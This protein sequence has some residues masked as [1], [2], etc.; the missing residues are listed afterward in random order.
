MASNPFFSGRIPQ[1]LLDQVEKHIQDTGESK[2]NILIQALAA[3]LNF[4]IQLSNSSNSTLEKRLNDLEQQ[5]EKL[6]S[7]NDDISEIKQ[8]ITDENKVDNFVIKNDNVKVPD[9]LPNSE[10]FD[11]KVINDDNTNKKWNLVGQMNITD[12]LKLPKLEIQDETK[13]RD[14]LKTL[15]N[16][17]KEKVTVVGFY[18]FKIIGKEP[19]ARGKIIYEVYE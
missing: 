17:K 13:F 14:K 10:A 16:S 5:V 19:G 1:E 8:I 7:L 9:R 2:T 4:P 15:N 6:L 3:Y 12:I 18:Q 11:N